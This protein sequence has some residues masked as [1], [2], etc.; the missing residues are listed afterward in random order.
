MAPI[1]FGETGSA[2]RRSG[3][4]VS[5]NYFAALGLRPALGRFP[6]PQDIAE[7]KPVAV[8]SYD[9]WQNR[10]GRG[11][12]VLAKTVRLNDQLFTV[13]GVAPPGFQGTVLALDCDV[14]LPAGLAPILFPGSR[15]LEDR[16][17][18]GYAVIG[19]L[20]AGATRAQAERQLAGAMRQLAQAYPETND[21]LSGEVLAFWRAPR[22][23][24][25]LFAAGLAMLQGVMLLL[26]L[27]ICGNTA[28][29]LLARAVA[30]SR[31]IAT[32]LSVGASRW[33][34]VQLLMVENLLLGLAGAAVGLAIAFWG[35]E[36]LRAAR[37]PTML[38]IKIQTSVDLQGL[39]FTIV[40]GLASALLFGLAP[41]L[42]LLRGDPQTRL[43]AVATAAPHR[44][45]RSALMCAEAGLA[46][47]VL[48]AAGLFFESFQDTR[49]TDPG[50][51]PDG[52][53]LSAYDLSVG[54][55][56]HFQAGGGVD[57]QFSRQ[58]AAT[59][60]ETLRGMPGVESAAISSYV[61]L[62]IHGMPMTSF[63]LQGGSAT[64]S[65]PDRGL[66]NFVTPDY[67]RTMGIPLL[68]GADFV[69]LDDTNSAQQVI[70]NEEFVRRFASDE[71]V[72]GLRLAS[73]TR[74][75][76]VTGV[77]KNSFSDSFGEAPIPMI[78][79][80]YRDRPRASGQ[81]HVRTRPGS[82]N[83]LSGSVRRAVT[84]LER[85]VTVYDV[86]TLAEHVERNLVLRRIPARLFIVLGPLLLLFAAI[87]VYS[88]VAYN[89]AHRITEIGIRMALGAT[90]RAVV[91]QLVGETMRVIAY[92]SAAGLM[93]A[94]IVYMHVVP[95]RPLDPR[96]F[97][98]VPAVLLF[99]A[100]AACWLPARRAAG[101][102]PLS[103][104]RE[105]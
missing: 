83:L 35:T 59:V 71:Q 31:E 26:L 81:I 92:G 88:V 3:L 70:V 80:S 11:P 8:I 77:V 17:Q 39:L 51:K 62:D 20:R 52:V 37:L 10:F 64:D 15:E 28:N 23:P 2:E 86:R 9:V 7:R 33:R 6:D 89:V 90:A 103:A 100:T 58:F 44:R 41:A 38:P 63:K 12:D 48:V 73:G 56:G 46:I 36:A 72:V 27:A 99:V 24:Q 32:R 78:Y 43:R 75:Y 85:G 105:Q 65:A 34:I 93:L 98:G 14:W 16:S 87:G 61:P 97:L 84:D 49:T 21:K 67:F 60:L 94:L 91:V 5:D 54:A 69:A 55:V 40:L 102:D 76:V 50:F 25:R 74:T 22:G 66:I 79:L 4:L 68:S 82:E 18:R 13:I 104:L 19:N 57:P 1:N 101:G 45:L 96:V 30:R 42:Q 95:G 47:M 53:L 29:L